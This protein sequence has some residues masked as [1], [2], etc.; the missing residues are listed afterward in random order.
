MTI[1][2]KKRPSVLRFYRIEVYRLG[3]WMSYV[4]YDSQIS[5]SQKVLSNILLILS[6]HT[7]N[8]DIHTHTHIHA[9]RVTLCHL[10]ILSQ[11]VKLTIGINA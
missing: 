3:T 8:S 7:H 11:R 6:S 4:I 5:N 1:Q 9:H 10:L 2:K